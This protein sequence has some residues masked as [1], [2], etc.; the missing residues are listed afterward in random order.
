MLAVI[1]TAFLAR[2]QVLVVHAAREAAREAA[3]D[4]GDARVRAAVERV[5]PGAWVVVAPNPGVGEPRAVTVRFVS[6]TDL[7]LIGA[8]FPDPELSASVTMRSER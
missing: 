7:P 5:L 1:Q 6:H 4:G 2:D 3:V 8:V